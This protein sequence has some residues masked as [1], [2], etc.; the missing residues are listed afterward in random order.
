V[1]RNARDLSGV[2]GAIIE[3][4]R[5]EVAALRR[6]GPGLRQRAEAR[7]AGAGFEA[8]LRVGTSIG[9]IAEVKRRSPSAGAIRA[10]ASAAQVV[11]GYA[12]AG[13]RAV[14]VLTDREFFG[15]SLSDLESAA[16][17]TAV[18]LLRKDFTVDVL[19]LYE[20]RAAGASAVLLIARILDPVELA[21]FAA[22]ADELQL[23]ALVEVHDEA[24]VERALTAGARI[25]GVNNRDLTTFTTDLGV[26][27]RLGRYLPADVLLVG[28]SG[29][30]AVEDVERLAAA[31]VDAVLVGEAL[32]RAADPAELLAGF[33][34]VAR[35]PR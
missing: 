4:K 25:V 17:I 5:A 2:L 12:A 14:S 3:V 34:A 26:T 22:L 20:A 35:N 10:G 24:E 27:E 31:G 29:I 8:A 23:A 6:D 32:M 13:A 15:G 21:D 19:Q 11:E 7:P 1:N 9:V 30:H 28:E 16:D 33:T 18:P